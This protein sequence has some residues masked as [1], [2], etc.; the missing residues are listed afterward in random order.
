MLPSTD[1]R[2]K[3]KV[4]ST[5]DNVSRGW[6]AFES[7]LGEKGRGFCA[8]CCGWMP[9]LLL[10]DWLIWILSNAKWSVLETLVSGTYN[11]LSRAPHITPTNKASR[12]STALTVGGFF[13]AHLIY[14]HSSDAS[15]SNLTENDLPSFF[16]WVDK[17]KIGCAFESET[18]RLR[19]IE[20]CTDPVSKAAVHNKRL[21]LDNRLQRMRPT[22]NFKSRGNARHKI[23]PWFCEG[24]FC[25]ARSPYLGPEND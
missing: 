3:N 15:I 1:R 24:K 5:S 22:R 21:P 25:N 12:P 11:K 18:Q 8:W 13:C 6:P 23:P 17:R 7:L 14:R 19:N 16:L 4:I 9:K 20:C 2:P 10:S